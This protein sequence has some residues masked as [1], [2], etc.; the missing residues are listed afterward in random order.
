MV[1]ARCLVCPDCGGCGHAE[2]T[3]HFFTRPGDR[4][5]DLCS[6][7]WCSTCLGY[8]RTTVLDEEPA[9]P[10]KWMTLTITLAADEEG[11]LTAMADTLVDH[12]FDIAASCSGCEVH[13]SHV[14]GVPDWVVAP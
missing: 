2:H 5:C 8:G 1:A 9:E 10:R 3:S 12:A 7:P 4:D 13:A 14:M 11:D 6:V